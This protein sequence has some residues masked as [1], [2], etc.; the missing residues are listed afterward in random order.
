MDPITQAII[1]A[2][3]AG[4]TAG[5]TDA[6]KKAISDGYQALKAKIAQVL[7]SDNKVTDAIT[8]VEQEPSANWAR[9]KLDSRVKAAGI[10]DQADLVALANAILSHAG[11]HTTNSQVVTDSTG[12]VQIQGNNNQVTI[13]LG[14]AVAAASA[15]FKAGI[16]MEAQQRVQFA[17]AISQGFNLSELKGLCFDLGLDYENI[18]GETKESKARELVLYCDRRSMLP[19]LIA[20][21]RKARPNLALP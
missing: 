13:T 7:G 5:L 15:A 21:I 18:P 6:A 16:P 4:A 12:V 1:T 10:A 3:T 19:D 20:A 17:N 11:H 14:Q 9:D 2:V 8:D